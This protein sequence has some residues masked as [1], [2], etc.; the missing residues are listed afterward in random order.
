M[1][2]P[3]RINCS[4][5][6]KN[7]FTSLAVSIVD[8]HGYQLHKDDQDEGLELQEFPDLGR[9]CQSSVLQQVV[10]SAEEEDCD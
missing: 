2:V 8:V 7:W 5:T 9:D 10:R 4:A 1:W 6:N 3:V